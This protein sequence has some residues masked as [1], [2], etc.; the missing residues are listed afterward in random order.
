[1]R[2]RL[3]QV[4]KGEDGRENGMA[5]WFFPMLGHRRHRVRACAI[6]CLKSLLGDTGGHEKILEIVAFQDPNTVPIKA[7]YGEYL[8]RNYIGSLSHDD[9]PHVRLEMLHT[10][11]YWMLDMH[12]RLDHEARL[13]PYVLSALNDESA[14]A[15]DFALATLERLGAQYEKEKKDDLK[16]IFHYYGEDVGTEDEAYG[17]VGTPERIALPHPITTRPGLG[18]RLIVF[19]N[20]T[21]YLY[22]MV[23]EIEKCWEKLGTLRIRATRLLE[24]SILCS[25]ARCEKELHNVL[26][27]VSRVARDPEVADGVARCLAYVGYFATPSMWHDLLSPRL[28]ADFA[29][30]DA[31]AVFLGTLTSYAHLLRG[32]PPSRAANL[33]TG[34]VQT[35][36]DDAG[37]FAAESQSTRDSI[38]TLALAASRHVCACSS[39]AEARSLL[40]RAARVALWCGA[41]A[42]GSTTRQVGSATGGGAG[43]ATTD[44]ALEAK[45]EMCLD[46]LGFAYLHLPQEGEVWDLDARPCVPWCDE[47]SAASAVV[48]DDTTTSAPGEKARRLFAAIRPEL[49]TLLGRD[50]SNPLCAA[51]P[52]RL[53]L[54]LSQCL[55]GWRDETS[56][57]LEM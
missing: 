29:V 24:V 9:S 23:G 4:V 15:S 34:Q 41:S 53:A 19:G 48:H 14:A 32:T 25:E 49:L 43:L 42:N 36:F 3:T 31:P 39:L 21:R 18:T 54:V 33:V 27:P 2:Y 57:C 11:A 46:A 52:A 8:K 22:A 5:N 45:A 10:I 50:A 26:P 20:F 55:D 1:M 37:L 6:K 12:E 56:G 7:F 17:V 28:D 35:L 13:M 44:E 47:R 38:L 51:Q 40:A 16:D 30:T